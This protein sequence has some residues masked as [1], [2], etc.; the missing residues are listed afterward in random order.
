MEAVN[1]FYTQHD[2]HFTLL[3]NAHIILLLKRADANSVTD[4][5]PISLSHSTGK[6]ISKL[7]ATRL[8][9][10]LNVLVS[11][12]QSAFIKRRSIHDNFL[13]TQNII[14]ELHRSGL[15]AL[16][17]KLDIAKA[18]D[19]VRW[20][21]LLE[22]LDRMGFGTRW[23]SWVS[24]LLASASSSVLLNGAR[25]RWFRHKNGLRQG[26]PPI[27]DAVHTCNGAS[28]LNAGQSH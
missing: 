13:Y 2:Q 3:N 27:T 17:L 4:Y 25:G 7:L 10:E 18:F 15:P 8:A 16:F 5:R 14:K 22:V 12:S 19:S 6:V 20:D 1:F 26:D 21:F 24:I 28:T 11:R 9:G 23:R